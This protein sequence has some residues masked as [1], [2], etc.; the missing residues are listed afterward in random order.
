MMAG[1]QINTDDYIWPGFPCVAFQMGGQSGTIQ[2]EEAYRSGGAYV[3]GYLAGER[4][5][6][7]HPSSP[8]RA[9]LTSMLIDLREQGD[10]WPE[11]TVDLI[12]RAIM[13]PTT[14]DSERANRLLRLFARLTI[15]IDRA[16]DIRNG[17]PLV[18]AW[19]ESTND[20]E[21]GYLIDYLIDQGWLTGNA[22][23]NRFYGDYIVPS[24]V[25]VTVSGH[26]RVEEERTLVQS[27]QGF[28]AMWLDQSLVEVYE[29]GIRPAVEDAG[30][31]PML[32]NQKEHI[33]K[34]EDEIIAE[35]R[36]SKFVVADFTHNSRKGVRGSVYY[37]AGFAHGFGLPVIFATRQNQVK[38]LH[39]DASPYSHIAWNSSEDLRD[40]LEKRIRAVVGQGPL[41]QVDPSPPSTKLP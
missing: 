9:R 3:I 22:A 32:I 29:N 31:K 17:M 40:Q 1:N 25:K 18:L 4:L 20:G 27:A 10:Q 41:R 28:V 34:I 15:Q 39:F 2:V 19:S 6:D 23:S 30:Y 33:N 8:Y 16:Y 24:L 21:V 14:P 38:K 37:E 7:L 13:A 5:E 35:I 12:D 11:V 26:R 36:Q